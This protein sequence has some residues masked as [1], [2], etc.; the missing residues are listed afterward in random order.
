MVKPVLQKNKIKQGVLENDL[1]Y[2][3]NHNENFTYC[4]I[5]FI[6]GRNNK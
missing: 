1:C 5:I 2:V 3:V 4:C 6:L